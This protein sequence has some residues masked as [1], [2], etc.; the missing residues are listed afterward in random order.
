MLSVFRGD[1]LVIPM[2]SKSPSGVPTDF[3]GAEIKFT[4]ATQPPITESTP[5]VTI[6]RA[7][8]GSINITIDKSLTLVPP[9][10]YGVS[11]RAIYADGKEKTL[12]SL[13]VRVV[14][15]P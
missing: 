2:Y 11:L 7:T 4:L 1:T 5:G 10:T 14:G 13:N 8:L 15:V 12:Y 9:K 6:D 3:T